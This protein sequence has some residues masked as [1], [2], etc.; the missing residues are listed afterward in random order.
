MPSDCNNLAKICN[1]IRNF[2][3]QTPRKAAEF[4]FV[5]LHCFRLVLWSEYLL[6]NYGEFLRFCLWHVFY[7]CSDY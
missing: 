2:A 1:C 3:M 5:Y 4:R 7:F 6:P